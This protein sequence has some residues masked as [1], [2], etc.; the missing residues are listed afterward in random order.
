MHNSLI[1]NV[2]TLFFNIFF[3]GLFIFIVGMDVWP[4]CISMYHV[5]AVDYG[6]QKRALDHLELELQRVIC[7]HV[8]AGN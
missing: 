3:K 5:Y 8:G 4:A 6:G 2:F 7:Y 1:A